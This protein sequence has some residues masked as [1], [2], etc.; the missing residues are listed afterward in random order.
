[1]RKFMDQYEAYAREVNIVKAQRTGGAQRIAFWGIGKASHE[2]TEEDW[3]VFFLGAKDCHPVDTFKLDA[4]IVK[5]KM[6]TTVQSAESRV[7]NLVSDFEA[8]LVRLS[9][10]GFAEAEPKR[11]VDYLVAA[12]RGLKEDAPDFKHWLADYMRR[13]DEVDPLMAAAG[14]A[15]AKADKLPSSIKTPNAGKAPKVVVIVNVDKVPKSN[16]TKRACFKCRSLTQTRGIQIASSNPSM[17]EED[18]FVAVFRLPS[19][20]IRSMDHPSPFHL[21]VQQAATEEFTVPVDQVLD[22]EQ[23][24]DRRHQRCMSAMSGAAA[25]ADDRDPLDQV[26]CRTPN[27]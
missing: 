17:L 16:F 5:L 8:V 19:R 18:S 14:I 4:A 11:S 22:V 10:E 1:M 6:D 12:N 27:Q 15:A 9:M 20:D 3:K 26:I 7:S 13:Y 23:A 2:L 24:S 21:R 25:V